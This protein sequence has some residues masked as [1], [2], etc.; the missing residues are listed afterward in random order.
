MALIFLHHTTPDVAKGT[1]YGRTDLPLAES[2][3]AELAQVLADLPQ[4]AR[5]VTSPLGRCHLLAQRVGQ[6]QGLQPTV[7]EGLTEMDFGRWEMLPWN[8]VPRDQL[9]AWAADFMGARP[10]GGESVQMLRDRVE[11][12]LQGLEPQTL[13][14]THSGVI[15]AAAAILG[16]PEGWDIDVKFGHW[17]RLVAGETRPAP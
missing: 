9:D 14:V 5:I 11:T 8:A 2:F 6:A 10:H 12:A 13:V 15:R 16:H 1:C 4:V 3:E 17:M 7:L